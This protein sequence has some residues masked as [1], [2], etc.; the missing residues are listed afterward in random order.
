MV[1][2]ALDK[3]QLAAT[4]PSPIKK[5][6]ETFYFLLSLIG[7]VADRSIRPNHEPTPNQH[8][9]LVRHLCKPARQAATVPLDG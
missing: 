7:W 1:Q 8:R 5:L 9:Y 4:N 6:R 3:T 2:F